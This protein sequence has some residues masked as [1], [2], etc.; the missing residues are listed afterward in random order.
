HYR[1]RR[2]DTLE[3]IASRFDV[4]VSELQRWNH[5]RT[6]RTPRGRLLRIYEN[7]YPGAAPIRADV[8][9]RTPPN[10]A[11]TATVRKA[12]QKTSGDR[13]VEHRVLPGETLWSIAHTYGT[14]VAA[15]KQEN[16]F[17]ASRELRA[18]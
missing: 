17:L 4:S 2:G 13:R 1:V 12:S 14:T 7:S 18:G 5:L 10:H 9:R 16:H 3:G 6:E 15:L 11:V 8:S